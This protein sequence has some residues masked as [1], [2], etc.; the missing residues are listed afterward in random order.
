MSLNSMPSRSQIDAAQP[1]DMNQTRAEK[2][3]E[4]TIEVTPAGL[5]VKAS[6]TGTLS[7]IPAA[8]ERLRQS[9]VLDLVQA[10][11]PAQLPS[12]SASAHSDTPPMCPVHGKPMKAMTKPDKNGYTHWCTAKSGDSF[13]KERG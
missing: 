9:G 1:L 2:P 7:S 5:I 8:I 3:A 4:I 6:Y 11:A 12:A 13:C 10:S